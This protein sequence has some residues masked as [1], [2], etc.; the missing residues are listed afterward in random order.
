[1]DTDQRNENLLSSIRDYYTGRILKFGPT[2]QGVDWNNSEGQHLRF[3]QLTR[4]ISPAR[5]VFSIDDYGCGYGE[6]YVFLKRQAFSIDYH[7][8][9]I[10]REMVDAAL[11]HHGNRFYVGTESSRVADYAVAS[12]IFNVRLSASMEDWQSHILRTL[13]ILNAHSRHGF[14][15]NCLTSY[16]DAHLMKEHLFYADP[17]FFF[18]HCKKRFSQNVALLHD[19]DLFEFTILVRKEFN[20]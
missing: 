14:A 3:E 1:M 18:D 16:S 13:T 2:H 9:D 4:I 10:S 7:G 5:D 11:A 15:F 19:Y 20:Q 6:L 17:C 8:F 12:G